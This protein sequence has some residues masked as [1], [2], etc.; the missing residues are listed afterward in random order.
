MPTNIILVLMYHRHKVLD[1]NYEDYLSAGI[2]PVYSGR[3]Q[4]TAM[5]MGYILLCCYTVPFNKVHTRITKKSYFHEN[6]EE[7]RSKTEYSIFPENLSENE[8]KEFRTVVFSTF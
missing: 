3:T 1:L 5:C 2:Y 7:E 4:N 6:E 8:I